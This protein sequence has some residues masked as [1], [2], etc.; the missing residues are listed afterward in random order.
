MPGLLLKEYSLGMKYLL[1]TQ[2]PDREVSV[3]G[4]RS[5]EVEDEQNI[6][7]I[8]IDSHRKE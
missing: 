7:A 5:P 8:V 2:K 1:V 6:Q 3:S 4:S